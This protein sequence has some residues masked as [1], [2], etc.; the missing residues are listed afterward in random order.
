[1]RKLQEQDSGFKGEITAFSALVFILMLSIVG[2][3]VESA[4]IQVKRS[5]KRATTRLAME[6][7][8]AEY[9]VEMLKQYDIFVHD[10]GTEEVVRNRLAYYGAKEMTH[11]LEQVELLSDDGGRPFFEQAVAYEKDWLGVEDLSFPGEFL[12]FSGENPEEQETSILQQIKEALEEKDASLSEENNPLQTVQNLKNR[13]LLTLVLQDA[14]TL[15]NRT[16]NAEELASARELQAGNYRESYSSNTMDKLFFIAYLTEHFSDRTNCSEEK[17]LLYEQEYLIGG[18]AADRDNL[19]QVCE[20]ILQMRMA[21]NYTYLL[22]DANKQKEAEAV[23]TVVCSAVGFPELIGLMKQGLLLG[24]AYGE[25]VVDVR[26]LL[27]GKKVPLMKTAE[28]WQL[29]LSN[30]SNLGTPDEVVSEKDD[31]KG[32]GYADYL[33]CLLVL[34]N[35]ETLCMRS[36]DLMESNLHIKADQCMTRAQIKST[37]QLRSGVRDEFE[38]KFGYL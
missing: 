5:T 18:K 14:T 1:M 3:L 29:Q 15:S 12:F 8:F 34:E 24:W 27:K 16:L 19:E 38:T 20:K 11:A 26:V 30:L 33:K 13:G 9:H 10:G 4:S 31:K 21:S 7:I 37:L 17:A 23:A 36:L 32:L 6:S 25:S 2:A 28:S 22:T 35:Q